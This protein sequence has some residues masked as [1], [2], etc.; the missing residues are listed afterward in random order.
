MPG[1]PADPPR[2]AA[3]SA[4]VSCPNPTARDC[5]WFDI[6]RGKRKPRK[7]TTKYGTSA[8]IPSPNNPSSE[9][10]IQQENRVALQ[11]EPTADA[12]CLKAPLSPCGVLQEEELKEEY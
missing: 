11:L 9:T 12:Q 10:I 6:V 3:A 4:G 7:N 1:A 2:N 5:D 8:R